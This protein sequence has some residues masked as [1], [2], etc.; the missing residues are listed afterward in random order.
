MRTIG[1]YDDW[2][3]LGSEQVLCTVM[4]ASGCALALGLFVPN[5]STGTYCQRRSVC[6]LRQAVRRCPLT[7]AVGRGDCHSL[8]HSVV[9]LCADGCWPDG[10]GDGNNGGHVDG[11]TGAQGQHESTLLSRQPRGCK[12]S[13]LWI[14]LWMLSANRLVNRCE[15]VDKQDCGKVD[16]RE[17]ASLAQIG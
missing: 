8:R 2:T 10:S 3:E 17:E 6:G 16:S 11:C 15:A 5:P 1:M 9:E 13:V 4:R 12:A 14:G 7:S